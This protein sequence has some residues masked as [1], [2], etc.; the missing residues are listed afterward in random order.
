M[1]RNKNYGTNGSLT[2]G[3]AIGKYSKY[4]TAISLNTRTPKLNIFT[5]YS[6]NWGDRQNEFYL[7]REQNPYTFTQ[8]SISK[9]SGL[10]HN[11]KAGLDYSINKKN[12]VGL[13][14]TGNYSDTKSVQT[15]R[16]EIRDF[17]TQVVDSILKSDQSSKNLNNNINVN[18][19]HQYKDTLGHELNS[20]FDFG[21]YD[22]D[23]NSYIPNEYVTPDYQ[24][25]LSSTYYR[26]ITPTTIN[27]FTFKS[28]YTQNLL[29]GKI[30]FGVKTSFVTTDNTFNFYNI[31]GNIETLDDSRSNQFEYTENVNAVYLNYQRTIK[32]I[33]FQVGVRV[34]NTQSEGDLKSATAVD[35][36]NVK[37]D[38]TDFFPS[39]GI[40][41][42]VH[43]DHS[44]AA[45]F[46]SR[47]DRPNYQEL[48]PFEY[49]LDELSFR[50]GNPFL[51]PQYSNKLN[52][53]ILTNMLRQQV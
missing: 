44:I 5:N 42:N 12:N 15:N 13:M 28:D 41:Y 14:V 40:T 34:E 50:K 20:D 2:A 7:Y 9:R 22:S 53:R 6:N 30:G 23:R 3:Y 39:A 29:K 8:S 4:N 17:S 37:R 27:I 31:E 52:Y 24:T 21:R 35:D 19:N 48:N 33:D 36:K 16:N 25:P 26:S 10:S 45:V 18:L 51:N 43:K 1:K 11:Y 38:Y 49:K 47:I 46:S 32:K